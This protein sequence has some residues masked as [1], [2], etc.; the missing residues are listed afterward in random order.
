M[1]AASDSDFAILVVSPDD[2]IQSRGV[3]ECTPRDNVVFELGLF[4]GEIG[5]ERTFMVRPREGDIRIPTDLLGITPVNYAEGTDETLAARLAVVC[6]TLR[7]TI[8]QMGP[9]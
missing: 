7:R 4:I 6:T 5:R 3:S 1:A 2:M 9:R 8:L